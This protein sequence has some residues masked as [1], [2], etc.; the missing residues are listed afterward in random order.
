[1]NERK[2][3]PRSLL[4]SL[5]RG[6]TGLGSGVAA[7]IVANAII[8]IAFVV[9]VPLILPYIGIEAYG[10]VGFYVA[11]QG[12]VT[13]LDL[14][15]NVAITRDFGVIG[16][17]PANAS[18][19]RDL[20]RTSE[21]IYLGMAIAMALTW[22]V[23]SRIILDWVN[24]SGLSEQT[25][26]NSLLIM[27]VPL[28]LQ[29]P[30]SLYGGG[31][32]GMHRQALVSAIGV[33]FSL[34]RNLGVIAILHFV[35]ASPET[36]FG[37]NALCVGLQVPVL[38]LAMHSVMPLASGRSRF[39]FELLTR[40]WRFVAGIG[41]VTLASTLFLQVDKFVLSR[42]VPLETFGYYSLAATV[43]GGLYWLS[44]PVFRALL[45]RLSKLVEGAD[46][47]QL[48]TLYH[49]GTQLMAVVILPISTICA[50][51]PQQVM[52]LWQRDAH[53]ASE[54]APVL[55]LLMAGGALNA[56]LFV[57]YTLQ[58]AFGSTRIQM[59]MILV[60]LAISIPLTVL[61]VRGW[62]PPGAAA[63]TLIL[64]V[65]FLTLWVPFVHRR[66]IPGDG[67]RWTLNDVA[68]PLAAAMIGAVAARIAYRDTDSFLLIALQL[69]AAF[70]LTTAC[71]VIAS[72]YARRWA[73]KLIR[74]YAANA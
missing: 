50:A 9:S 45:P 18:Q 16:H 54:T 62:G 64:N 35:S 58:L 73:A 56:I 5:F 57:P 63:A 12:I 65:S 51:F 49:Q 67:F 20:L 48:I 43:A 66:F 59:A 61:F 71:C 6:Q 3:I 25:V 17:D 39:R 36:Y 72:S 26:Y 21:I 74:R 40:Q 42:I 22:L 68:L 1:M 28:A 55:A 7:N 46:R 69:G 4:R 34:L 24:P 44:Q 33:V 60:G 13:V 38:M 15:L 37:W 41:V 30:L 47:E 19:L 29:F 52:L 31:L 23:A 14:G 53:L 2:L 8:G 32:Y 70:F 10:L 27:G 11:I